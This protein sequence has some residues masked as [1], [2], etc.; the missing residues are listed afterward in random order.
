MT[1]FSLKLFT[2]SS[3]RWKYTSALNWTSSH[4]LMQ[5]SRWTSSQNKNLPDMLKREVLSG[6]SSVSFSSSIWVIRRKMKGENSRANSRGAWGLSAKRRIP[7][8]SRLRSRLLSWRETMPMW[9]SRL[10]TCKRSCWLSETGSESWKTKSRIC[11]WRFHKQTPSRSS[12]RRR[13]RSQTLRPSQYRSKTRTLKHWAP[14][15]S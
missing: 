15:P 12:S 14:Q 4:K 8:S 10:S 3:G 2:D 1:W 13:C 11:C 9:K 6:I 5:T 7:R